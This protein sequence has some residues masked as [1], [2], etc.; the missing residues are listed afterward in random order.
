MASVLVAPDL[1]QASSKNMIYDTDARAFLMHA[2]PAA[3]EQKDYD[4]AYKCIYDANMHA[5]LVT[6][7]TKRKKF[8]KEI[9]EEFNAFLC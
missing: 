9:C 6:R 7:K 4:T 1:W 8:F 5:T 2:N 3:L